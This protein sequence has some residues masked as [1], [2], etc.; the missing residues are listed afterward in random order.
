AF[1]DAHQQLAQKAD[2]EGQRLDDDVNAV[3]QGLDDLV[4]TAAGVVVGGE[5]PGGLGALVNVV[6][7]L[8]IVV[9][10]NGQQGRLRARG[11]AV[12]LVDDLYA[13]VE[14]FAPGNRDGVHTAG[15]DQIGRERIAE[16]VGDGHLRLAVLNGALDLAQGIAGQQTHEHGA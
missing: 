6:K 10:H 13:H 14:P 1:L 12:V 2:V 15:A 4:G 8:R 3:A 11:D 9:G 7:D 16:K 5:V